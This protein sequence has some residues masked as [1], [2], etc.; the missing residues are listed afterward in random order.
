[1]QADITRNT[2]DRTK[3]YSRV[4]KQ[5]GRVEVDADF[6]EALAISKYRQEA[7]ARDLIGLHGTPPKADGTDGE[8]FAIQMLGSSD[9]EIGT[10]HYYVDGILCENDGR[11]DADG[12]VQNF[13]YTAQPDYPKPPSLPAPPFL[14]YLDVW[15]RHIT[16]YEDDYIRE[17]ALGGLDTAT[18]AKVV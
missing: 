15:E 13:K 16:A 7:V 17:K 14:V 18:R 6:N 12:K 5:Q 1:M 9:F 11:K 4:L 3:H 2:F 8:G 10:G